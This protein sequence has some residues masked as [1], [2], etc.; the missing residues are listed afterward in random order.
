MGCTRAGCT[1]SSTCRCSSVPSCC[2]PSATFGLGGAPTSRLGTLRPL[3]RPARQERGPACGRCWGSW[4]ACTSV[5]CRV[6]RTRSRV[7]CC[8]CCCRWYA[9][10]LVHLPRPA[11][12]LPPAVLRRSSTARG[13]LGRGTCRTPDH[14]RPGPVRPLGPARRCF[15]RRPGWGSTSLSACSSAC[16]IR[17]GWAERWS[18][19]ARPRLERPCE[20]QGVCS[21]ARRLRRL[22]WC[23]FI[24]TCRR[25]PSPPRPLSS[26]SHR[27]ASLRPEAFRLLTAVLNPRAAAGA[28]HA[29]G[30]AGP[31]Q[32]LFRRGAR[33]R[34]ARPPPRT[35]S[36]HVRHRDLPL[37]PVIQPVPLTSVRLLPGRQTSRGLSLLWRRAASTSPRC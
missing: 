36:H 17:P 25:W 15:C 19:S 22:R 1:P 29:A 24:R 34:S 14:A 11:F 9:S 23:S 2:Q 35:D 27:C 33:G 4:R 16:C 18:T 20:G 10:Q 37:A 6:R 26:P 7:S 12:T 5:R 30:G 21:Q 8:H 13:S 3:R 31:Q 32:Q 28:G